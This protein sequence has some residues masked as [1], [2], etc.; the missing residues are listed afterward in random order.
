MVR[1]LPKQEPTATVAIQQLGF[2]TYLPLILREIRQRT[3][4][5]WKSTLRLVPMFL[6]YTFVAFKVDDPR[7]G[8]IQQQ[9]GVTRVLRF[10]DNPSPLKDGV[11][12]ALRKLSQEASQA[13]QAASLA[14]PAGSK[15]RIIDGPLAGREGLVAW[16]NEERVQFLFTLFATERRV[17]VA[18]ELCEVL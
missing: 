14:I 15:V 11:V 7:W 1:T 2:E 17:T 5:P 6:G 4:G 10:S 9:R 3:R 16:S 12:P 13:P 8:A 18:R